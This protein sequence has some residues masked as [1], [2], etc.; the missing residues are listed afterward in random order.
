MRKTA[1]HVDIPL[2]SDGL[3]R[4]ARQL[5]SF[6]LRGVVKPIEYWLILRYL[7][8]RREYIILALSIRASIVRFCTAGH[9]SNRYFGVEGRVEKSTSAVR[10]VLTTANYDAA[11]F[12]IGRQIPKRS[13]M[14][15][16]VVRGKPSLAAAPSEP[17][18]TQLRSSSARRIMDRSTSFRVAGEG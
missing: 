8:R 6:R 5:A 10:E 7:G 4:G 12:A 18:T 17:P 11:S 14:L 1:Q 13:I 9:K 3:M 16:N 2:R 15:I